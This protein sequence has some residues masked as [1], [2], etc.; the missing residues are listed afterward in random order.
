M[1]NMLYFGQNR[2]VQCVIRKSA[3]KAFPQSRYQDNE[4]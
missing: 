1:M 4:N 3:D 2:A